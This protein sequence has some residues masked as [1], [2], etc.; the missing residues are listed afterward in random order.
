MPGFPE[1]SPR[2]PVLRASGLVKQYKRVRAVDGIDLEV[3]AGQ[4]VTARARPRRCSC[5]SV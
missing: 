2:A 5:S 1:Q 3:G 4:R